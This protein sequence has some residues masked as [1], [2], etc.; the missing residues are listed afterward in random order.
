M[1]ILKTKQITLQRFF[2]RST[3]T[4]C[5]IFFLVSNSV[6]SAA[7]SRM[8]SDL[9]ALFKA[10]RCVRQTQ[11]LQPTVLLYSHRSISPAVLC[12]VLGN[13]DDKLPPTS[14][15]TPADLTAKHP[16]D[17]SHEFACRHSTAKA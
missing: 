14:S 12:C 7:R 2:L 1:M 9:L 15:E 16:Q 11:F 13:T 4:R 3:S 10:R 17:V 6:C 8:E 5:E